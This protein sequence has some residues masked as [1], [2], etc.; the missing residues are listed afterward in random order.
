MSDKTQAIAAEVLGAL[1]NVKQIEAF[2]RRAGGLSLDEAYAVTAALRNLRIARGEKPIGRKIGF[3]N[4]TIWDEYQVFAP[5]WGDMYDT[6]VQSGA[7]TLAL[8]PFCEPRLEPEIFFRFRDAPKAGMDER[9]LLGCI[10]GVGHGFEI[11]QSLFRDWRFGAADCVVGGGLHGAYVIGS[12]TP[13]PQNADALFA[14][15]S[16]FEIEILRD[17]EVVDRGQAPNVLDGPLSAL[18]HL[19]ELLADDSNNPP[20]QAG[21][22]VTTGTVTRAFVIKPGERWQTRVYG[23]PLD[24]LDITFA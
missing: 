8:A 20:I 2:T 1:S 18:R 21:E 22:I 11:V 9:A 14:Q 12:T 10:G 23:L 4:R 24:G 16:T 15:L 17:G 6:T 7:K 5:I 13:V 3:T 19:V